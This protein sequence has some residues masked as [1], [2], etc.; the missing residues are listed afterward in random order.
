MQGAVLDEKGN[1]LGSHKGALVYTL[2]QR[3]GF[4]VDEHVSDRSAHYVIERNIEKNTITVGPKPPQQNSG[5]LLRLEGVNYIL[6][7]P[8]V[9]DVLSAQT[10]YRQIPQT[11]TVTHVGTHSLILSFNKTSEISTPGQSC[12]LYRGRRCLGGGIIS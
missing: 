4:T 8:K 3:H 2:G 7:E 11:V 9:G 1:I 10:R 12:V 5:D 6:Y